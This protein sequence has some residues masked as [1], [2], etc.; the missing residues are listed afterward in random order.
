MSES[1]ERAATLE[2]SRIEDIKPPV[3]ELPGWEPE[4]PFYARLKRISLL[5]LIES[6]NLP[7]ELLKIAHKIA[8]TGEKKFN[9]VMDSTPE[10]LVEFTRLLHNVARRSLI[11]PTYQQLEENDIVLTDFQ[12]S[13]IFQYCQSGVQALAFFRQRPRVD[14]TDGDDGEGLGKSAE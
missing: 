7:N 14:A 2:V 6:G 12:L 11:E 1:K 5:H 10:E 9:P 13:A 8:T 4:Q 3:V